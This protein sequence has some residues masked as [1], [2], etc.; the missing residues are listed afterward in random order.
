MTI[1]DLYLEL[2]GAY[3]VLEL[4]PPYLARYQYY[5]LLGNMLGLVTR[6]D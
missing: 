4:D 1:G 2:N 3:F 6:T 5:I